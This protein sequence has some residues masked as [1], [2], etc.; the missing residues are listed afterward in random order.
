M[1]NI[2]EKFGKSLS[3]FL[4]PLLYQVFNLF[5]INRRAVNY[6]SEKG[7]FANNNQNFGDL[8][9]SLLNK[10]KILALDVGAQGGFNSDNFLPEKYNVFFKPI[11]VEPLKEEAEKLRKENEYVIANGLWSKSIKKEIN[12]LGNRL[13]SSSMYQPDPNLFDLHNI[14][15]KDYIN[16]KITNKVEVQCETLADSLNSLS[17]QKLDYLKIDT[18]GAEL[19][20]LKGIGNFRPLIIKI[21]S[22]IHSMYKE[23]P[24]WSELINFLYKLNYIVIDWKGIGSHS[25]RVPAEMDMVLIPNFNE[26]NG[27][28]I[29]NQNEEKF[30][31]LM[32]IFGQI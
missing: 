32:L 3:K 6:F 26:E 5:K 14:K 22:H 12:I 17:I 11:L 16:Y 19:E 28:R 20:I 10:N 2:L 15:K 9:S 13:G 4:F 8:I 1:I 25:T 29:I 21:E 24:N 23:V 30:I 7:F 27:K 18:Q 31:S